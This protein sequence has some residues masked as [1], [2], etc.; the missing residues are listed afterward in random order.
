MPITLP[1]LTAAT[2]AVLALLGTMELHAA[3]HS[4]EDENNEPGGEPSRAFSLD[5]LGGNTNPT[6]TVAPTVKTTPTGT[7]PATT[8]ATKPTPAVTAAVVAS[9]NSA[10]GFCKDIQPREYIIDCLAERLADVNDQIANQP[11]Y[12]HVREALGTAS[13]ELSKIARRSRSSTLPPA[14]YATQSNAPVTTSRFLIPVEEAA[15]DNAISQALAVIEEAES[16]ILLRSSEG[17]S[18]RAAQFQQIADA[19]GSNKVLLRSVG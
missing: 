13:T 19:V 5:G 1:K 7:I 9:L 3:L 8:I 6:D 16:T 11:G 2:V 14:R 17:S 15:L 18:G 4:D 12:E 10:T